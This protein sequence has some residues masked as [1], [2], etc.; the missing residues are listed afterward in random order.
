MATLPQQ[1]I[2]LHSLTVSSRRSNRSPNSLAPS[3]ASYQKQS[4]HDI[5]HATLSLK[6]TG[7][8]SVP[9]FP[10]TAYFK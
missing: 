2:S 7:N 10:M 9:R 1:T 8:Y 3:D 6:L 5:H 4:A